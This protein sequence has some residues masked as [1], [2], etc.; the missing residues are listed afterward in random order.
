[1]SYIKINKKETRRLLNE[2]TSYIQSHHGLKVVD[3]FSDVENIYSI[4]R[5]NPDCFL[6]DNECVIGY[7]GPQKYFGVCK[8]SVYKKGEIE[9]FKIW[10]DRLNQPFE[11]C[12]YYVDFIQGSSGLYQFIDREKFYKHILSDFGLTYSDTSRINKT[13]TT[14]IN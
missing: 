4:L 7:N 13:K 8:F 11:K 5:K 3:S 2:V 1:M 9:F 14:T 12:F 10:D 6:K